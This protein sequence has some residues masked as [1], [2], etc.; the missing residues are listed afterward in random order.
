M[1]KGQTLLHPL[2]PFHS[3]DEFLCGLFGLCWMLLTN[4]LCAGALLGHIPQERHIYSCLCMFLASQCFD[5]GLQM[6]KG[7]R[8]SQKNDLSKAFLLLIFCLSLKTLRDKQ[9][10]S[11]D[12]FG[13]GTVFFSQG[14]SRYP[15]ERKLIRIL[16]MESDGKM[17][18]IL[19]AE[20]GKKKI[21]QM[22]LINFGKICFLG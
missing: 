22:S 13:C 20:Q 18:N 4:I 5:V 1:R 2:L 3:L 17:H 21:Q 12:S 8:M 9:T 19:K 15:S 14:F 6:E 16:L 11:V 10:N 7:V